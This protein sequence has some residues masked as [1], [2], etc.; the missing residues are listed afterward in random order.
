MTFFSSI[1]LIKTKRNAYICY[2]EGVGC[3]KLDTPLSVSGRLHR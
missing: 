2:G 3:G 1:E